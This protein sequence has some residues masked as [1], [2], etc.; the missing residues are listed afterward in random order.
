MGRGYYYSTTCNQTKCMLLMQVNN[1]CFLIRK[2]PPFGL[3]TVTTTHVIVLLENEGL[4]VFCNSC[5]KSM[6][7]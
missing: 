7:M 2:S 5:C 3:E 4:C 6:H 1:D